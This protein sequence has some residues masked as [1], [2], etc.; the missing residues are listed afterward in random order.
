VKCT[1]LT[2]T[3]CF[4]QSRYVPINISNLITL[5][6]NVKTHAHLI[7][8]D[9]LGFLEIYMM[10]KISERRWHHLFLY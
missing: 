3:S 7:K 4:F 9:L 8:I 6:G 5:Q 10:N 2:K 1:K